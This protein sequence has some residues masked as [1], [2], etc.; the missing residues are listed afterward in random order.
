[1][2]HFP[3]TMAPSIEGTA[4]EALR[5][6]ATWIHDTAKMEE[7]AK[8]T[9]KCVDTDRLDKLRPFL[10]A[11][12]YPKGHGYTIYRIKGKAEIGLTPNYRSLFFPLSVD[13]GTS[14]VPGELQVAGE[15][16]QLGNYI[17]FTSA[18]VLDAQLD[19]LIVLL[20]GKIAE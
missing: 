12:K 17:H 13:S 8:N 3:N 2:R 5:N 6:L 20:P 1:P 9:S 14:G 7:V 16:L 18:L 11:Q 19:C 10:E 15:R 4:L